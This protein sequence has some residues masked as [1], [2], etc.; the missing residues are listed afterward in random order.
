MVTP[1]H[2][3]TAARIDFQATGVT[4]AQNVRVPASGQQQ[5]DIAKLIINRYF[6]FSSLFQHFEQNPQSVDDLTKKRMRNFMGSDYDQ[7]VEECIQKKEFNPSSVLRTLK[8]DTKFDE[9]ATT[10]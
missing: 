10:S 3:S 2:F 5:E 4:P 8:I 9:F 1:S 6:D 7:L